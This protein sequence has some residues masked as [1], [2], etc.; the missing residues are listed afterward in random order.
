M[1]EAAKAIIHKDGE[2]LLQLRSNIP[3]IVYP[4]CWS[5]FGGEIEE[6][7]TPWQA[8]QRELE[9]EIN[10]HVEEG[11]FLYEWLDIQVECS[12]HFYVLNFTQKKG[13]LTLREGRDF[14]WFSL[15]ESSAL[16]NTTPQIINHLKEAKNR[17]FL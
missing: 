5:F 3:S 16:I 13:T 15:E 7:E 17:Y 10:W 6:G 1:K 2:Y 9:E 4:N 11:V 12:V 14:R 8:L